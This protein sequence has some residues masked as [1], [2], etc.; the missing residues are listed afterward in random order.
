[1]LHEKCSKI[2]LRKR[3]K[4][5]REDR[6]YWRTWRARRQP[7]EPCMPSP[8][9]R[10]AAGDRYRRKSMPHSRRLVVQNAVQQ[11]HNKSKV[12]T[13]NTHDKLYGGKSTA[14]SKSTTFQ[15]VKI[16]YS[17]LHDLFP[18][19]STTIRCSKVWAMVENLDVEDKGRTLQAVSY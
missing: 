1:M 6:A 5:H 12:S 13:V 2:I 17:L 14:Y 9:S 10:G 15:H 19:K 8:A 3:K 18:N 11:V 7:R 4:R 16:R